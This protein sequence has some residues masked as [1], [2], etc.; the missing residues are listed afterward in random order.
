MS[1]T[2]WLGGCLP[3]IKLL[4]NNRIAFGACLKFRLLLLSLQ[5]DAIKQAALLLQKTKP[6]VWRQERLSWY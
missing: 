1:H 5:A 3:D 2:I 6:Y 4:K